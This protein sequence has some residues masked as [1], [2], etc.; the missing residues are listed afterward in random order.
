MNQ[1]RGF[2]LAELLIVMVIM[3]LLYV[4]KIHYMDGKKGHASPPQHYS[5]GY[6]QQQIANQ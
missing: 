1:K 6:I 3:G 2:G 5:P 4:V